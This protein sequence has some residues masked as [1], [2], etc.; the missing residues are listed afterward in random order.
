MGRGRSRILASSGDGDGTA[1][2]TDVVRGGGRR[3][4]WN[5]PGE[6]DP[7]DPGLAADRSRRGLSADPGPVRRRTTPG[8]LL[9]CRAGGRRA[10][11]SARSRHVD[12]C[13]TRAAGWLGGNGPG[14]RT[15]SAPNRCDR[16]PG[17][18]PCRPR[19]SWRRR[20]GP[21]RLPGRRTLAAEGGKQ[22]SGL[23]T[24]PARSAAARDPGALAGLIKTPRPGRGPRHRRP[25][26]PARSHAVLEER[27][28][29]GPSSRDGGYGGSFCGGYRRF[30]RRIARFEWC[31][32]RRRRPEGRP[33]WEPYGIQRPVP[34]GGRA[35]DLDR[36]RTLRRDAGPAERSHA[37][38]DRIRFGDPRLDRA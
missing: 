22:R 27:G 38:S 23:G 2:G 12:R 20:A 30:R 31:G 35:L 19:P 10:R 18:D 14:S 17:P 34:R 8:R 16:C 26:A 6:M 21:R 15:A 5:P 13:W 33:P 28:I 3:D 9:R 32:A 11:R 29:D 24:N 36:E 25:L 7:G 37:R 1:R 4:P